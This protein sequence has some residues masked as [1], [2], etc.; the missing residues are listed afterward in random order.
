MVKVRLSDTPPPPRRS[1][2]PPPPPAPSPEPIP[3]VPPVVPKDPAPAA[4][5]STGRGLTERQ[6]VLGLLVASSLLLLI[7][8]R[9][10]ILPTGVG[11]KQKPVS[12]PQATVAPEVPTVNASEYTVVGGDNLSKIAE[13]LG[14][15][16]DALR[17]ANNL[18]RSSILQVGQKLKVPPKTG[19]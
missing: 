4:V 8:F 15:S 13:K 9:G 19:G 18:D 11:P 14:V 10:C 7:T 17:Q 12:N 3:V 1:K 16:V 2:T 5:P 6:W